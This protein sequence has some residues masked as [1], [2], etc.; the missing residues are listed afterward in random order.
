MQ[1]DPLLESIIIHIFKKYI[2]V[3]LKTSL[4]VYILP[5]GYISRIINIFVHIKPP[6]CSCSRS[7][8][9][10]RLL[11]FKLLFFFFAHTYMLSF[12]FLLLMC[13]AVLNNINFIFFPSLFPFCSPQFHFFFIIVS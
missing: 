10:L 8:F 7:I 6:L 13:L 4:C 2:Y 5:S 3:L 1:E 9:L 11:F 12:F